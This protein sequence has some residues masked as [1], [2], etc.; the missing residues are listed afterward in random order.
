MD[1]EAFITNI[2]NRQKK[3]CFIFFD[4]PYLKKGKDLYTNFYNYEDH[5]NLYNRIKLTKKHKWIVTYDISEEIKVIY[6]GIDYKEYHINYS[7]ANKRKVK[8]ILF[9]CKD[10]ILPDSFKNIIIEDSE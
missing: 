9:I 7:T 8:E 2:I 10:L 1:A 3:E 6:N 4:S 5:V